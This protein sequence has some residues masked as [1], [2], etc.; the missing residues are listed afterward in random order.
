MGNNDQ[1]H[2]NDVMNKEV[3]EGTAIV[4]ERD[5]K[6]QA[7]VSD[8]S[9]YI[10]ADSF[11]A[12]P[13]L[14]LGR[15]IEVRKQNGKCP[16]SISATESNFEFSPFSLT[17]FNIDEQTKS[18]KPELRGSFIVDKAISAQVGFLNFLSA[19]LDHKSTFSLVVM[20]QARGNIIQDATWVAAIKDWI[21]DNTD[22]M[23]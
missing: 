18:S 1:D 21:K 23:N 10:I 15:V 14:L 12:N 11:T 5:L 4:T 6:Q 20:D 17:G 9:A 19:Q 7:K 3:S 8:Q 22:L 13:S 16:S 2:I